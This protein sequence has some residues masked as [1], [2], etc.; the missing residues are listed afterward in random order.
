MYEAM[1]AYDS[2]DE[3]MLPAI[4][5]FF[6]TGGAISLGVIL[7]VLFILN[8][9]WHNAAKKKNELDEEIIAKTGGVI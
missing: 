1:L 9:V 5:A 4:T 3:S 8:N 2:G 6:A 7:L